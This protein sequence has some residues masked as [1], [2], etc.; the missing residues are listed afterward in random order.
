MK[1]TIALGCDEAAFRLK[2]SIRSYLEKKGLG[3]EDFGSIQYRSLFLS[4]YRGEGR[5][6]SYRRQT[7]SGDS[8]V[9]DWHWDGDYRQ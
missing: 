8:D 4:G 7:P 5:A 2:E 6:I 3:V 9:R 1:T